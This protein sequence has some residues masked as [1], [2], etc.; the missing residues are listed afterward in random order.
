MSQMQRVTVE[1]AA[2]PYDIW[3][4]P[5]LLDRLDEFIAP[6][7]P[8]SIHIV[9]NTVVGPLYLDAIRHTCKRV[10]PTTDYVL[11]DG[12]SAKNLDTVARVVDALVGALASEQR[13]RVVHTGGDCLVMMRQVQPIVLILCEIFINAVKYAHP[14][15]VP[16]ILMVDCTTTQ[17][18]QLVLTISDD[19]VG[20]P[21]GFNP[22]DG[23]GMGFNVTS[24]AL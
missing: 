12:E 4:A 11:A 5:G 2:R 17:D 16:L 7:A 1:L 6:L 20:S 3:I 9:T 14:S 18:G 22:Q 8:T 19:G 23:G 13:V 21:E 15:G 24:K 10:A